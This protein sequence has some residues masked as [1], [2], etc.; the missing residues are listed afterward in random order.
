MWLIN[1]YLGDNGENIDEGGE[2]GLGE[3]VKKEVRETM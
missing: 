1:I 3:A 2:G